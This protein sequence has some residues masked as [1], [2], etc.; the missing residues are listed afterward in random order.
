MMNNKN[1]LISGAGIA[2]LTLANWLKKF[3]FNPTIVEQ[4]PKIREGGYAIDFFGSGFDVAEKMQLLPD[5]ER[6]DLKIQEMAF[7]DKNNKKH[8]GLDVF[9]I[10]KLVNGRFYNLLR[11]DLSKVIYD[12]LDKNI[13]FIFGDTISNIEQKKEGVNIT[14]KSGSVRYFDL[15]IGADGLHSVVRSLVFGSESQFEKYFGYYVSSFTIENYLNS[16]NN[17]LSY[18]VPKKQVSIYSVAK[19]K[20]TAL[21][22]FTSA[23]KLSFDHNDIEKQ[24]QILR[25]EF[26]G[27]PWECPS[28]LKR[29]D[30]PSDFYFD[31]VSQIQMNQ[32]SKQRVTLVGDAC[33]CPSLLSGQGSTLAMVGAYVLAG[34]LKDASGNYEIAFRKYE[35]QLKS[36][37][38]KKQKLAET[39]AGKLIPKSQFG[40]WLRNSFENILSSSFLA[41][42]FVKNYMKDKIQLKDYLTA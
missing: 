42:W 4:A 33:Y 5:L 7:V 24:K 13:E 11:S 38:E 31:S 23:R 41:K 32:W 26:N 27:L 6:R 1:I 15:V 35:D 30:E 10:R 34:E 2:G 21:F 18:N 40:I 9:K 3:G 16:Q 19:N 36:F 20:L 17:F 25:S 39:F 8:G 22:I 12:H 29:L 37:I 28:L 14:F